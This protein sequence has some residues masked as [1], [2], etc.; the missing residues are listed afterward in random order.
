[1]QA[2]AFMV[3]GR[4]V[5]TA[6]HVF[7]KANDPEF[8]YIYR[9]F[10]PT[11]KYKMR[12]ASRCKTSD[13]LRLEFVDEEIPKLDYLRIADDLDTNSGY[14]LSV[15]G[16]PQLMPGHAD[17]TII[18]CT[19]TNTFIRSTFKNCQVDADIQAGNSGG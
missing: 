3:E 1:T 4:R 16:F 19:V 17:V 18:P 2:T 7:S 12:V 10:D 6:S 9:I 13:I 5:F 14:K 15:I 11:K 8:C